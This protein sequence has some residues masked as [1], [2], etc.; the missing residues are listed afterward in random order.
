MWHTRIEHPDVD[1]DEGF[2]PSN[3]LDQGIWSC[4]HSSCSTREPD[5]TRRLVVEHVR[6]YH[7]AVDPEQW[8]PRRY[9]TGPRFRET[10]LHEADSGLG[11]RPRVQ[12]GNGST[13]GSRMRSTAGVHCRIFANICETVFAMENVPRTGQTCASA[14]VLLD[15]SGV[16]T[17]W[18]WI[19][20][21]ITHNDAFSRVVSEELWT[22]TTA[23]LAIGNDDDELFCRFYLV[24]VTDRNDQLFLKLYNGQS[25]NFSERSLNHRK[26]T[27]KPFN[28]FTLHYW[29]ASQ[30][31][32]RSRMVSVA[33]GQE[34]RNT[35]R[36]T[37]MDVNDRKSCPTFSAIRLLRIVQ[38]LGPTSWRHSCNL[39]SSTSPCSSKRCLRLVCKKICRP[40]SQ[41]ALRSD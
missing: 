29:V 26:E 12:P 21:L 14:R 3:V 34:V 7:K 10:I 6:R 23:L 37:L 18:A 5:S 39:A 2:P 25:Q 32:R 38:Q 1:I 17:V 11:P 4:L 36:S 28:T 8:Y 13:S 15:K 9:A 35:L 20:A 31:G 16:R 27:R 41:S 40:R 24:V 22:D 30:P 33:V 19:D